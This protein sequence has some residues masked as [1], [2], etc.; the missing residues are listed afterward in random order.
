MGAHGVFTDTATRDY[1]RELAVAFG[2]AA[3]VVNY[4]G[5]VAM[6]VLYAVPRPK[7]LRG[8]ERVWCDKRP[9]IDNYDK[10]LLDAI[11]MSAWKAFEARIREELDGRHPK[12][13][14]PKTAVERDCV[15]RQR[16]ECAGFWRDDA[17][18]VCSTSM[19]VYAGSEETPHIEVVMYD[20][21]SV[22]PAAFWAQCASAF[23]AC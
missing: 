15:R 10:A 13:K 22:S 1:E 4:A 6:A 18:L 7:R 8:G 5:P 2:S 3:G 12:G 16:R 20:A 19:K 11:S 21:A 14:A 17:Q 23:G 9:D